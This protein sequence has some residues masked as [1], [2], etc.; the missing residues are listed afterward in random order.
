ML[1]FM[2]TLS[3]YAQEEISQRVWSWLQEHFKNDEGI[4]Y[5]KHPIMKTNGEASTV[6]DFTIFTR[7][8]HPLIIKCL[9]YQLDDIE[10][11]DEDGWVMSGKKIEPIWELIVFQKGLRRQLSDD[12]LRNRLKPKVV[13]ALP[14]I[15]KNDFEEKCGSILDNTQVIWADGDTTVLTDTLKPILSDEEWAYV[16]TVSQ[17]LPL[18]Q[19]EN[20]YLE[21][22]TTLGSAIRRLHAQIRLLDD[23]QKKAAIQVAPGPQRIRGLAGTGKTVLLAMKAANLHLRYPDS[24]ILFTFNT[25]SLYNQAR[26]LISDYYRTRSGGVEPNWKQLHIRHGWGGRDRPGVYSELCDREGI[27][28]RSYSQS[29]PFQRCYAD[30]LKATIKSQY[31]YILVDEAQDFPAEFFRILYR[32]SHSPHQIYWAYDELQSLSSIAVPNPE[33]LFG[34]DRDGHPYVSLSGNDYPGGIEKDFVL[35]RSYRC[36]RKILMLAHAL[37]LGLYSARSCIQMLGDKASWKSIGYEVESGQ[38]QTGEEVVITRPLAN[39]PNH[40]SDIYQDQDLV[41]TTVFQSRETELSWVA[42]SISQDIRKEGV[43]HEQIIVISL[44]KKKSN[45]YLE[46]I[47]EL[48]KKLD[49]P[50]IIPGSKDS[51]DEFAKKGYVTLATVHKAKGNEAYVVY[52]LGF[53][54]LYEYLEEIES[55]NRAFTSITRSKALVR[56]TGT[57]KNMEDAKREVDKILADFPK[58]KFLFPDMNKIRRL[59]AENSKR[60]KEVRIGHKSVN[61]LMELSP[62]ALATLASRDPRA[63]EEA[64]KRLTE[65]QHE[66]Q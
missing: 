21:N 23:E 24:K 41:T 64:I 40:M 11:A 55:R 63:V 37:G 62:E 56:I 9:P 3:N 6:P 1:Q 32:L 16:E 7:T 34:R 14:L 31:D 48:L 38:F 26:Q 59:D 29:Y 25:R 4:C 27:Q 52:V 44:N 10:R 51:K 8:N 35:H 22:I 39:S 43:L 13:L 30:A 19:T 42:A 61:Q 28:F 60:Y 5:Y 2:I 65:A 45:E 20:S 57:G 46:V 58:F 18:S 54:S 49:V 50:S 53:D 66:H 12:R 33:D 47:Q 36:P 15:M 17:G